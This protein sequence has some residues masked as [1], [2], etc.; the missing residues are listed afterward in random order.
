[1]NPSVLPLLRFSTIAD[2]ALRCLP[3]AVASD[4]RVMCAALH[5]SIVR[6]LSNGAARWVAASLCYFCSTFARFL[7]VP[8]WTGGN[9]GRSRF[10]LWKRWTRF[11]QNWSDKI[12]DFRILSPAHLP[13][14]GPVASSPGNPEA[15]M[16][17][18]DLL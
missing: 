14:L 10:S 9:G 5:Q 6:A 16:T 15:T 4:R 13:V 8:R 11:D 12:A 18:N 2:S 7:T 1:M 3:H 17:T